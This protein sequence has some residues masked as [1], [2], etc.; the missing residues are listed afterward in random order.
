MSCHWSDEENQIMYALLCEKSTHL[1][2]WAQVMQYICGKTLWIVNTTVF[3]Q[4][5]I[6][7]T[8]GVTYT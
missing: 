3:A 6:E 5:Q 1:T 4:K 7:Q 2:Y 8:D